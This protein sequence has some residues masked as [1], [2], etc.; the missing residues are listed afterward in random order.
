VSKSDSTNDWILNAA[1]F[2]IENV[3]KISRFQLSRIQKQL[4]S[5]DKWSREQL[6]DY[7]QSSLKLLR[8]YVYERSSF[9]QHFHKGLEEQSL[10]EL[11][12]LT[13]DMVMENFNE[14]V[15]DPAINLN[16]IEL[17][18]QSSSYRLFQNKYQVTDRA[19]TSGLS[20]IFVFNRLEWYTVLAGALRSYH[21]AGG[22]SRL[23][24]K[25]KSAF[26]FPMTPRGCS[27]KMASDIPGRR[28][29]AIFIDV[30]KPVP[31]IV[32]ELN[33]W[34][35]QILVL[36]PEMINDLANEQTAGSLNI[37]PGII[38]TFAGE[39]TAGIRQISEKA[40][41]RDLSRL[42]LAPEAGILA[43]ECREHSGMHLNED[44]FIFEVVDEKNQTVPAGTPGAKLLVTALNGY[45]Q[46]LI[47]YELP[48][49]LKLAEKPCACGRPYRLIESIKGFE[50]VS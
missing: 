47:R 38:F 24:R 29:P 34:Q 35:P 3:N 20:E 5:R 33:E 12:V 22:K 42:L 28:Q 41:G 45:T 14:L 30:K 8:G 37:K 15:T 27:Y 23:F 40:W 10:R 4:Q 19:G 25:N 36:Q 46:P 43:A 7:Q 16:D 48:D 49:A 32:R 6:E 13:K 50:V 9:Y 26:I 2:T 18:F 11:P 21:W 17:Y 1:C 31:D 39:A 44:L